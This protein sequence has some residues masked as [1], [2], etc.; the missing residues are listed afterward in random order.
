MRLNAYGGELKNEAYN[1]VLLVRIYLKIMMESV[2]NHALQA[3]MEGEKLTPVSASS[4]KINLLSR[5]GSIFEPPPGMIVFVDAA[6]QSGN[7]NKIN[8]IIIIR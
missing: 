5:R 7:I 4:S 3:H 8:E 2:D 1:T 6:I